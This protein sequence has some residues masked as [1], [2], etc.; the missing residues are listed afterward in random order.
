VKEEKITFKECFHQIVDKK[1]SEAINIGRAKDKNGKF[2]NLKQ[3]KLYLN[4]LRFFEK[5][6]EN[7]FPLQ[8]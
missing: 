5:N 4:Y 7:S 8:R 6:S 1:P 2:L 3:L